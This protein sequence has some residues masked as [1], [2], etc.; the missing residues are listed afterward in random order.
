MFSMVFLKLFLQ[1]NITH[2]NVAAKL[3]NG[4]NVTKF[5]QSLVGICIIICQTDQ[6]MYMKN[7]YHSTFKVLRSE[8]LC[9]NEILDKISWKI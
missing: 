4:E 8:I 3:G 1:N 9:S 2:Q 6:N 7:S 5:S